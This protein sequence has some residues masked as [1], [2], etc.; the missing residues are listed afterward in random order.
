MRGVGNGLCLPA[1][2]LR[3]PVSRLAE[4]DLVV[5]NGK[6][7]GLA[8]NELVMTAEA[9]ALVHVASGQRIAP[10]A[11]AARQGSVAALAGIGNP[12]RFEQTLRGIGIDVRVQAFPDHHRFKRSDLDTPAAALVVTEKDAE[13]IKVF[14]DI[15]HCWYVEIEMRFTALVDE[16][17]QALFARAGIAFPTLP[18]PA[19]KRLANG[20]AT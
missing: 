10:S 2:P 8:P 6:A 11:F 7:T 5:A 13:K 9:T 18:S 3:E 17:L 1:G 14:N 4:C 16:Q 19:P 15:D 20:A 12:V